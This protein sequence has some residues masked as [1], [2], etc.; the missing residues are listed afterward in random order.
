VLL[1]NL[2]T[3]A[4]PAVRDVRRYL[5]EFLG[6][7]R[8]LDMPGALRWALLHLFIL[9]RRARGSAAAYASIWTDQ[10]SPLRVHS[11]ALT[12]ALGKSL[13]TEFSVELAMSYGEPS[14]TAALSR[15]EGADVGQILVL[16]LFPHYASSSRGAALERVYALA[17]RSRHVPSLTVIPEFYDHPAFIAA[18]AEVARPAL[19]D[20]CPDHVVLSFHGVPERELRRG[21]PSGAHCLQSDDCCERIDPRNR[22]CYRAQSCATARALAAALGLAEGSYTVAFQS[23]LGRAAWIQPYTDQVLTQLARD[24]VR[25]VVVLSPAFVA[26]CLETLEEIGIRAREQ[27]RELGGEELLLVP[28]V[29]DHPVWVDGVAAMVRAH[30]GPG[31]R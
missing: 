29:N 15:L 9:P 21:D 17:G 13:G 30:A 8:V 12:Q 16:P 4:S 6:D 7:P 20:F 19:R 31:G 27:W 3:P 28:C 18:L 1:V 22:R 11:R 24:G 14:I 23:R 25:R 2:G 5:R 26:D 10:G